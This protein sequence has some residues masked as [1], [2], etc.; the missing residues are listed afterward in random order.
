[1]RRFGVVV[2]VG[3]A[4]MASALAGC[5]LLG[6]A[7]YTN[8]AALDGGGGASLA[9]RAA[10]GDLRDSKTH[11]IPDVALRGDLA[12]SGDRL[13]LGLGL[14]YAL[15]PGWRANA[16]PFAR[17]SLWLDPLRGGDASRD[18]LAI[19]S[20]DLGGLWFGGAGSQR[21]SLFELGAR[22]EWLGRPGDAAAGVGWGVYVGYGVSTSLTIPE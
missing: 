19:P 20:L 5:V 10:A 22:V 7:G 17:V 15:R 2:F 9:V 3:S 16:T 12:S 11:F 13:A 8:T 4:A 1:V 6:E 21:R 18:D 14:A